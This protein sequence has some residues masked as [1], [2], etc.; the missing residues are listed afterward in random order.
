V[1]PITLSV[2]V[3]RGGRRMVEEG[4]DMCRRIV[5]EGED[6]YMRYD[7]PRP[8]WTS[9]DHHAIVDAGGKGNNNVRTG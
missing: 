6:K 2:K 4:E 5:E 8:V 9:L 1:F 7:E 3:K